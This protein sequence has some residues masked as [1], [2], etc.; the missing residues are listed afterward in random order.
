MLAC[1]RQLMSEQVFRLLIVAN[2]AQIAAYIEFITEE[3]DW[4][5]IGPAITLAEAK[6]LGTTADL[7]GA[8][9]DIRLGEGDVS[10]SVVAAILRE[11]GV[12]FIFT[13]PQDSKLDLFGFESVPVLQE[14]FDYRQFVAAVRKHIPAAK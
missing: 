1:Q 9:L 12:P 3:A 10:L 4:V 2:D 13:A 5:P 7:D 11:R 14:P 6:H 8:V